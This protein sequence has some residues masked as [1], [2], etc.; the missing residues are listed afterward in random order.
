MRLFLIALTLFMTG[1]CASAQ[2]Q[3]LGLKPEI[4]GSWYNPSQDGHG[5]NFQALD[6]NTLL[7]FWYTYRP[8]GTSTFLVG[9]ATINELGQYTGTLQ[10][11]EGMVFGS[12][13][14]NDVTRT[15][16]GTMTIEIADCNNATFSWTSTEPGYSGGSIPI[17]RLT[18][19]SDFAC[20][21][22]P[23]AGNYVVSY[24]DEERV[25][26]VALF[27][28]NGDL[29][30]AVGEIGL[31]GI[32]AGAWRQTGRL[33][34]SLDVTLYD[35]QDVANAPPLPNERFTAGAILNVN[36]FAGPSQA[37]VPQGQLRGT[38]MRD[39]RRNVTVASLA[40]TYQLTDTAISFPF[41]TVTIAEDGSITG[42]AINGCNLD[43]GLLE[44]T[45]PGT[46][47]FAISIL[48]S[49]S[50]PICDNSD[51]IGAGFIVDGEDL[52]HPNEIFAIL[53]NEGRE[54]ASYF[55]FDR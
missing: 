40:G 42:T 28:P 31:D 36:G 8:D 29:Y 54:Y 11:T 5:F 16:W 27:L 1:W 6:E 12:F 21:D 45:A 2:A 37:A 25:D 34:M 9:T 15:N 30:F 14:P 50:D 10:I 23:V 49:D 41:G 3:L 38:H 43:G 53:E 55:R 32:G 46:N 22:S 52:I 26:G 39:Y 7:V 18:Q 35:M 24:F 48:V 4:T 20:V 51:L 17:Q 33:N 44:Q 47:Q 13:D 19:T